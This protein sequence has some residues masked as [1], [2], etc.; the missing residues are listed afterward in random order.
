MK[1]IR[2]MPKAPRLR[3][4]GRLVRRPR[5]AHVQAVQCAYCHQWVKPRYL[6]LPACVCKRCERDGANQTWKPSPA[7]LARAHAD[8]AREQ[9]ARD[10]AHGY[11]R[12]DATPAGHR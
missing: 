6:R 11:R 3:L 4:L 10:A 7:R 9:A 1:T 2:T 5:V 12:D 8:V